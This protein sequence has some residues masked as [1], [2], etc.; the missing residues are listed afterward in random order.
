MR[1][2]TSRQAPPRIR[3][4]LAV[5]AS[6]AAV[7]ISIAPVAPVASVLASHTPAPASVTIA[8]SLQSELGCPGD[9][10][11]ECAATFLA[12]DAND[13]VWQGTFSVPEGAWEYKAALNGTWDENYGANAVS[14]GPNIGVTV[15]PA[16]ANPTK[17]YYDH[18]SH[19]ITSDRN[20]TIATAAGNFQSELGCPGDW[21]PDC[22]RSWLQ[23]PDGNG[24]Y[25]FVTDDVPAGAYEFKIALREAWDSSYPASNV[26]FGVDALGDT[27]TFTYTAAT[28]AV[29]VDVEA[30]TPPDPADAA[31]ARHGLRADL[32]DEVFYFV[33]PDRF[34]N[35]DAAHHKGG[36]GEG[37]SEHL[38]AGEDLEGG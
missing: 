38:A 5:L 7:L 2:T 10:Q 25:E 30:S 14:N 4:R 17:F 20:S 19:W 24:V 6:A 31:L 23:D 1:S 33:L 32:T 9:W 22:L 29:T 13:I 26:P 18:G 27:V 8:G 35:G 3:T 15:P 16:D 11:P 28:N 12:Y 36:I 21:Q 34:D 37:P